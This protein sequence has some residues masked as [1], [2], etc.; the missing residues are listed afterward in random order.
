[1]L[2]GWTAYIDTHTDLAVQQPSPSAFAALLPT[3]KAGTATGEPLAVRVSSNAKEG[4]ALIHLTRY[5]QRE[6][7][8]WLRL[9]ILL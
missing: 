7:Q 8:V 4:S 5:L 1:M 3:N 9:M 2:T 6:L